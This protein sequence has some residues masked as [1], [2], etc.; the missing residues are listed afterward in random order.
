MM[1]KLILTTLTILQ[2][3]HA[4]PS[5]MPT[6][7]QKSTDEMSTSNDPITTIP[8]IL[9]TD[10]ENSS[11]STIDAKVSE[12]DKNPA[13][14]TIA[15][16]ETTM[17]ESNNIEKMSTTTIDTKF[18]EVNST[19]MDKMIS[20][21]TMTDSEGTGMSTNEMSTSMKDSSADTTNPITQSTSNSMES[22]LSSADVPMN[23]IA[24]KDMMTASPDADVDVM[25]TTSNL[26]REQLNE[27]EMTTIM[28]SMGNSMTTAKLMEKSQ[29]IS[30]TEPPSESANV[31][32]TTM[33]SAMTVESSMMPTVSSEME[34]KPV[35]KEDEVT[36]KNDMVE[37]T[38]TMMTETKTI[39]VPTTEK[40]QKAGTAKPLTATMMTMETT[41]KMKSDGNLL[42][43]SA[44]MMLSVSSIFVMVAS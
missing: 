43:F 4:F 44:L 32:A 33:K 38:T 1:I 12:M 8:S 13:S 41:T 31:E 9:S 23:M 19:T 39:M 20:A 14:N 21:N 30:Q 22:S 34:M 5:D 27:A 2:L 42:K 36:K 16:F 6:I 7:I 11:V 35:M 26:K 24:T 29:E 15:S 3:T 25:D 17:A 37:E 28:E 18:S 40:P 10:V